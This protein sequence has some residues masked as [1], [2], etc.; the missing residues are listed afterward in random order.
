MKN[1]P[2]GRTISSGTAAEINDGN[3]GA[4]KTIDFSA[5]PAHVLTLTDD[6]V[7]TLTPPA[8]VGNSILRLIQDGTGGWQITLPAGTKSPS[9]LL[10]LTGAANSEDILSLY[11]NG[12]VFEVTLTPNMVAIP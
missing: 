3:S 8:L 11:W 5:G 12:T 6:C 10:V 9:G 4:A 1:L 7:L 2:T